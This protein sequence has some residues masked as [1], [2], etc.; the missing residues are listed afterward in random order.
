MCSMVYSSLDTLSKS[1]IILRFFAD[2]IAEVVGAPDLSE[3][4]EA[5]VGAIIGLA[6]L[7]RSLLRVVSVVFIV[8]FELVNEKQYL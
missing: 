5:M 7:N 4:F 3:I 8:V 1:L 6:T 2:K